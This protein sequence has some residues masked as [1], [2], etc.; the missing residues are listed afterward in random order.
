MANTIDDVVI[1]NTWANVYSL[2]IITS[3]QAASILSSPALTYENSALRK[4][5]YGEDI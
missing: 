3:A 4:I 2:S 5:F 1:G